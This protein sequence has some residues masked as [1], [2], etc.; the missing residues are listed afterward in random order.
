MSVRNNIAVGTHPSLDYTELFAPC[1]YDGL[2]VNNFHI[3]VILLVK[4]KLVG[5]ILS[6]RTR[7]QL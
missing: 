3:A 7:G 5:L 2:G 6:C 1:F 4:Q